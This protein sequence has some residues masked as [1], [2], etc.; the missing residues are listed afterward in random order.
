MK[1]KRPKE[2]FRF[3]L[4]NNTE[5]KKHLNLSPII[6]LNL[7]KISQ[8]KKKKFKQKI[9]LNRGKGKISKLNRYN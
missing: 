3:L 8:K 4:K 9:I 1:G 7:R 5:N 2:I 6:I